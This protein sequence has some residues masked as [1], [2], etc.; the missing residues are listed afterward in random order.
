MH[1]LASV[2]LALCRHHDALALLERL[3][4]LEG[5]DQPAALMTMYSLAMTYDAVGRHQDALELQERVVELSINA[6]G[7]QHA[8]KLEYAR[9]LERLKSNARGFARQTR[10]VRQLTSKARQGR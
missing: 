3:R 9:S 5:S 4:A 6:H 10:P 7:G 8:E 2:Y 1:H